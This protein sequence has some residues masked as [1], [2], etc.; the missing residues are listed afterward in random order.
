MASAGAAIHRATLSD[1]LAHRDYSRQNQAV[2]HPGLT[3]DLRACPVSGHPCFVM[4]LRFSYALCYY[5]RF[6]FIA[7]SFLVLFAMQF[8][9]NS[10]S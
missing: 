7:I 5:L 8:A 9:P 10:F 6:T 4:K 2:A 3:E 1:Y